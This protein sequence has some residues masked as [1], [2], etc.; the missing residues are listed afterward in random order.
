MRTLSTA[1]R[2]TVIVTAAVHRGFGSE[3]TTRRWITPPVNLPAPGRRQPLY[4]LL[5]VKQRPV[6]LLNSRLSHFTAATLRW[7]GLL[8]TYPFNLPSSS[9]TVLPF[10]LVFSTCLPVLVFGTDQL[11]L[12]LRRFSWR[13]NAVNFGRSLRRHLALDDRADLPT[14]SNLVLRRQNHTGA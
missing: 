13:L 1:L 14:R 9:T 4:F 8:R 5:R 7:Q 2:F 11:I 3:L 6:F 10:A 12:L